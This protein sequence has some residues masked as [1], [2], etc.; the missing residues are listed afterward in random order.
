VLIGVRIFTEPRLQFVWL[1]VLLS[2]AMTVVAW[3]IGREYARRYGARGVSSVFRRGLTAGWIDDDT[4]G[5]NDVAAQPAVS[6]P[7]GGFA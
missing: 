4:G 7:A 5:Q 6:R 1:I 3:L 2:A